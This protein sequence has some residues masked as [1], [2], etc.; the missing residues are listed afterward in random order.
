VNPA[1]VYWDDWV[2]FGAQLVTL[3]ALVVYVWKTWEMAKATR[4][5]ALASRDILQEARED[6][7]EGLAPRIVVFFDGTP[8]LAAQVV[9][10]NAGAGTAA[11]LRLTFD[12]PIQSTSFGD[13][14]A[15][16]AIPQPIFPPGYRLAQAFDGWPNYLASDLPRQYAVTVAY[17]GVENGRSYEYTHILDVEA[18]RHR[19]SFE[20][21]GLHEL[22]GEVEKLREQLDRRLGGVERHLDPERSLARLWDRTGGSAEEHVRALVGIWRAQRTV[23]SGGESW[24]PFD[25]VL[26]LVRS[27]ALAAGA[28]FAV[29]PGEGAQVLGVTSILK[30]LFHYNARTLGNR[31]W[32]AEVDAAVEHVAALF[33]LPPLAEFSTHR[34]S[35]G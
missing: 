7:A 9:I 23:T 20:G 32:H 10:Q 4:D 24:L 14:L 1:T 19:I 27:H 33:D 35:A 25:P 2:L 26:E 28:A 29:Q 5:A 21:R 31:E 17:R 34:A 8:G 11:D 3:V 18:M 22:V 30:T 6:R 12:P 13:T 16:F 15:F